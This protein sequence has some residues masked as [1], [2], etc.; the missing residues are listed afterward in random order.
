MY[1]TVYPSFIQESMFLWNTNCEKD[2][3]VYES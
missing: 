2:V 1:P 3:N